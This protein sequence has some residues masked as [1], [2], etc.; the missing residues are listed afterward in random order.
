MPTLTHYLTTLIAYLT[1]VLNTHPE[2][3]LYVLLAASASLGLTLAFG[4][5]S[6]KTG[7]RRSKTGGAEYRD[8]WYYRALLPL[9]PPLAPTSAMPEQGEVLAVFALL[10]TVLVLSAIAGIALAEVYSKRQ[11]AQPVTLPTSDDYRHWAALYTAQTGID[12]DY[13]A[14]AY[15]LHRREDT[16]PPSLNEVKTRIARLGYRRPQR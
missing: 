8:D 10:L 13:D 4:G 7:K 6:R 1:T 9:M 15:A 16:P 12:P 11:E 2:Y 5:A 14:M 3:A